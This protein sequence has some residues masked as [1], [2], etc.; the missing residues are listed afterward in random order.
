MSKSEFAPVPIGACVALIAPAS[1]P[2]PDLIDRAEELLHEWGYEV[3]PGRH[4]RDH[5]P[6]VPYLAGTDEHRAEDLQWALTDP[7][8]DAVLC[9][10]GGYG[11]LRALKSV[12]GNATYE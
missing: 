9:A 3:I 7:E 12:D 10:R 2:Q 8:I 1:P 5:H 6:K 11:S 4:L